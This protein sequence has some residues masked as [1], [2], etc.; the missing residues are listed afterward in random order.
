MNITINGFGRIGRAAFKILSEKKGVNIVAINDL[1]SLDNLGYLLKYDSVYGVWD[2]KVKIEKGCIVVGK[3]RTKALSERDPKKLP[4]KKLKV[5]VVIESTGVFTNSEGMSMHKKAGAKRVILSAPAKGEGV[6]TV[7][8]GVNDS[9]H[10]GESLVSNASCTTNCVAPVTSVID[11]AFG[12]E[13]AGLTTIHAYTS[14]QGLVDSPT[15]PRKTDFRRGRA[16]AVN[17]IPTTTGAARATTLAIPELAGLFDGIAVR[18][19][20]T[21]GSLSDMTFLVKKKT[22][23]EK[24]NNAIKRASRGKLKGIL[25]YTEDQLVSSDIVGTTASAIVDLN[26]TR[27]VGEDFVKILAWYDNE[28]AYANRLAEMAI[29]LGKSTK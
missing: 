18:V 10:A 12:I 24:V 5:D 8:K 19:P 26:F 9:N 7:V 3:K 28:W 6:S 20:V 25:E 17:M 4:W 21:A 14:G 23:V 29:K 1:G 22:T 16:S 11:E 13:R 27:V 15:P 2:K